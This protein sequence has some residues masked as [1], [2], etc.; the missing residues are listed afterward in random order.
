MAVRFAGTRVLP[1][2]AQKLKMETCCVCVHLIL[3]RTSGRNIPRCSFT[4]GS[5]LHESTA[6][7]YYSLLREV[8]G[9]R[10]GRKR[11]TV[12][13]YQPRE[14]TLLV[15]FPPRPHVDSSQNSFTL[16][17]CLPRLTVLDG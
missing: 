16:G 3:L 10:T 13:Y 9:G 4:L 5:S 2:T 8:C 1:A 14:Q 12:R 11:V 15:D 7:V 17:P 6:C